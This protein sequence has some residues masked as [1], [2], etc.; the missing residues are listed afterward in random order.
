MFKFKGTVAEWR[1]HQAM[2]ADTVE[3][4]ETKRFLLLQRYANKCKKTWYEREEK[5]KN[6]EKMET[7]KN[8]L[9]K[10][11]YTPKKRSVY[12]LFA[13]MGIQRVFKKCYKDGIFIGSEKMEEMTWSEITNETEKYTQKRTSGMISPRVR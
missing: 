10:K 1:G 8:I 11:G 13:D 5:W 7:L 3:S 9:E 2:A 12:W 4:Q 6:L